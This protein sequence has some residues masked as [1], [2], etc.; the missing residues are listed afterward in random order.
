MVGKVGV[1]PEKTSE[2]CK[3]CRAVLRLGGQKLCYVGEEGLSIRLER[4]IADECGSYFRPVV[5]QGA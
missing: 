2:H 5:S 4:E 3:R 1:L